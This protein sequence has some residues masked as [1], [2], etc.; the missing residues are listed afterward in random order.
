MP[1]DRF[2]NDV[3]F[4]GSTSFGGPVN[5]GPG[6]INDANV[7]LGAAIQAAK[8][9][10]RLVAHY[11]QDPG[12]NVAAETKDLHIVNG[13]TGTVINLWAALTGILAAGAYACAVDLQKSTGGGAFA[14]IL[15][16][17]LALNSTNTIRVATAAT[18]TT[19]GLVKG[20]ILRIVVTISGGSGTQP[21][22][23]AVT[24]DIEETPN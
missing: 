10:H 4:S 6:V 19:A 1:A 12:S 23:L 22:G 2:A 13:T 20:D 21:Q 16:A 18:I 9:I 8:V 24:I 7:N 17:P 14:S 3:I 11:A 15:S 5:L